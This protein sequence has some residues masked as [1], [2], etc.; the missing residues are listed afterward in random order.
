MIP[1]LAAL[2]TWL[3]ECPADAMK[4][5]R[6]RLDATTNQT[7]LEWRALSDALAVVRPSGIDS[8][9]FVM[10]FDGVHELWCDLAAAY[11][12]NENDRGLVRAFMASWDAWARDTGC[13]VLLI[14]HPP[15]TD[16]AYSGSTDWHAA[17]RAVWTLSLYETGTG[18]A[19]GKG[20]G[21]EKREPAKA[22]RLQC[23]K[24]SYGLPPEPQWLERNGN[25]R[26]AQDA[27]AAA[28]H[29]ADGKQ[30]SYESLV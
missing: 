17:A 20:G 14:A 7:H 2:T 24:S 30:K 29:W 18:A 1:T 12:C 26:V 6:K 5:A 3:P 27:H 4:Q 25:W 23:L 11:A 22:P 9:K 13:T 28:Q 16:A 21:K 19:T 10:S 8:V 15:K